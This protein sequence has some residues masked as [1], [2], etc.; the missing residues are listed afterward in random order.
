M[1]ELLGQVQRAIEQHLKTGNRV[2]EMDAHHTIIDLPPIAVVLPADAHRLPA[3]FGRA[4][5]VHATDRFAVRMVCGNNLL[6]VISQ[7]F[8]IPLD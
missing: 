1:R 3:A 8:F 2:A 6:A 5:F 4:R 7:F